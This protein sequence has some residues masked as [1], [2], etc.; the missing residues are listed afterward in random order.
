MNAA[1]EPRELA[2]AALK[3]RVAELEGQL[4]AAL[5]A[6]AHGAGSAV[7]EQR[8]VDRLRPL[9]TLERSHGHVRMVARLLLHLVDRPGRLAS[10]DQVIAAI[11]SPGGARA[12]SRE[13]VKICLHNA[14]HALDVGGLSAD[15]LTTVRGE[16]VVL[17]AAAASDVRA[18]VEDAHA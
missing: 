17:A 3:Q 11:R 14:R 12:P 8:A 10:Y 15:V 1:L 16:G 13:L 9:F 18:L 5:G 2:I 6:P 7:R 4:A